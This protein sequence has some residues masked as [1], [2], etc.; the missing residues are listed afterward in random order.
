MSGPGAH[1]PECGGVCAADGGQR[2]CVVC[3]LVVRVGEPGLSPKERYGARRLMDE[4]AAAA[5]ERER[6][7]R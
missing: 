7:P 1:C 4:L 2:V 6:L 5:D 3:G